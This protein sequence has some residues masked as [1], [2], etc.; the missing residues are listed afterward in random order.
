[1][2][3]GPLLEVTWVQAA[4]I[5]AGALKPTSL[6]A[7]RSSLEVKDDF[8]TGCSLSLVASPRNEGRPTDCSIRGLDGVIAW[9][10]LHNLEA[11]HDYLSPH[12]TL[13]DYGTSTA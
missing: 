3:A 8:Y 5:L 6:F 9:T 11:T 7:L 2:R 12:G 1:M 13:I 10:M 4:L